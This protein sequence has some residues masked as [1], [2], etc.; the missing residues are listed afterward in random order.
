MSKPEEN[1]SVEPVYGIPLLQPTTVHPSH[2]GEDG[3]GAR[4]MTV[5]R[6]EEIRRRLAEGRG[7]REIA[8]ALNCS[9]DTVR[10]VRDGA[11]HSPDAPKRL[12]DPLWMLQLDWPAIVHDLGLGHPLKFI[13][14]EKAQHLTTYSNFWKQ[15]YR[16]F[17]QYRQASVTAR[18]FDPGERVEVDYAG[19]A[20]EWIE[21]KTGEIRKAYVFVAGLGFSQLLFAWASEDMKSRNWLGAHRRMFNFYGGVPHVTVPDCLKQGVLKCHLY[22]PDLNPGYAQLA[23]QFSTAVV[24]AR[25]E[26]PKDKAIVEGLV[27]ILMRYAR[28]RHRRTRFTSLTQINQ[29][30]GECVERI[31]ARRHTRFGISRRERFETIEKAALK[32]LPIGD[33]EC[34]DWKNATLHPDCYVYIEGD[35]YSA[36]HIHRHKK[37]RIK[38]TENQ[39]E[40]FLSLERLA[41]HPRS[42]HR[43]GKRIFIDAH[44]PPASQAYYEATP[45]KLLS[46]SRFIHPDL[47]QLF[48]ELFNADVYGHLR[49]CQGFVSSCKKEINTV[50]HE[51]ASV[52]ITA[53]IATMRRYNR[54]RVPYFQ[55]L[56]AQAR[57]QPTVESG[58]REIV[59][60]PGNPM[61][62]YVGGA[63]Q[64]AEVSA[65]IASAPL[66]ENFKL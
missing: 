58:D 17:P 11:R 41:I 20:L 49:R 10:E 40:I 18:E 64:S 47:N 3:M 39:V 21:V 25:P 59:R 28:F 60:R 9:R 63:D 36:P 42:R 55:S 26:H 31:N 52:R 61:L 66:Q 45:Q 22:D 2:E 65:A 14:E 19:D 43:N 4:S 48:V 30:L 7:L 38:I 56:L 24:P 53:A 34:A 1:Q 13:W 50:G 8:R 62:R 15:F 16:K 54:F 33:F 46:Q 29:A 12:S 23:S 32:P 27:K 44:F 5:G 6:Y 57:K 37:L 51:L 35:Y